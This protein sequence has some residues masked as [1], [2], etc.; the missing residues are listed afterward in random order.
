MDFTAAVSWRPHDAAM[1]LSIG[2][3]PNIFQ[4]ASSAI[5]RATTAMSNDAATVASAASVNEV[6]PAMIDARQQLLYT[7]AAAK[8]LS[9]AN[10]MMGSLIDT[11]A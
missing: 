4:S 2:S 11:H 6:L 5:S 10:S 9:T 7:Q 8:M 1:S 3:V